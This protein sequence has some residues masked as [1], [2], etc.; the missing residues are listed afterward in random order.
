MRTH[1]P[2]LQTLARGVLSRELHVPK[3]TRIVVATSGGPDSQALL[4]VLASLRGPL[5]LVL[6]A[7]GIDHGL[8]EEAAAE[9]ALAESLAARLGIPFR[10][11]ALR[12]AEGGNLQAR[13]RTA[14]YDALRSAAEGALIATGHHADDRAETVLLRLLR[15][16]GP[17]GL[18]VLP[19]RSDDRIRPML[20]AR[21]ADVLAH[22]ERHR[23]P[24]A[25][26]P[27]NRSPRFLRTRVRHELLPMLEALSPQ[28]VAHLC[29]LA[30]QLGPIVAGDPA[31]TV[32][33][34][35]QDAMRRLLA[36]PTEAGEILLP[37]GLVLR[38][39]P[40]Q[41]MK[42]MGRSADR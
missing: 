23:I 27:S 8:R 14:R 33:R 31:V 36:H 13:A 39:G 37:G 38:R 32:P 2:T 22:L 4:D 34:A 17:R 3:G 41:V 7:H 1:P 21:R 25:T 16:A 5:G 42:K 26:D 35:T 9:L 24:F 40:T 6:E 30:D 10:K 28:I 12:V 20:R 19:P 18:A 15:G 11:T 29:A